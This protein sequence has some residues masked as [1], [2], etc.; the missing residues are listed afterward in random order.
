MNCLKIFE[1]LLTSGNSETLSSNFE[2]G[3]PKDRNGFWIDD[4][5]HYEIACKVCGR[6]Y[7]C[8]CDTYHGCGGLELVK[9][10]EKDS[11]Q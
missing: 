7:Q 1:D 9:V 11:F 6:V 4:G 5:L 2:L 3:H 8:H 10:R